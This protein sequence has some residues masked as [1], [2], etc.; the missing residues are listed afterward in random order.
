[1]KLKLPEL[2]AV[3]V[4]LD[5]PL[6]VNSVPVP[7]ADGV[8]VPE[9]VQVGAAVAVK[10][11][12][13]TLAPLT[14]TGWLVGL[15][16]NPVLFG[17][18]VYEPFA[19]PVKLKL[20]ELSAVAVP[21]DVPLRVNNVPVPDADGLTVPEILHVC[22]V[23]VKATPVVLAPLIVTAWLVGLN[24]NPALLGVTV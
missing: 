20:P 6:R 19:K 17:V 23:A 11:T 18:I 24:V 9:I 4:P 5:A 2:F 16:A 8:T 12:P 21:L 1:V 14:V 13:V 22:A 10:V 15:N 7:D 3:V